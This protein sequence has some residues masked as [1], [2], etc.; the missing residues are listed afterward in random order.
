MAAL[1]V[2]ASEI[3][4]AVKLLNDTGR[5]VAFQHCKAL[6]ENV[7]YRNKE[8]KTTWTGHFRGVKTEGNIIFPEWE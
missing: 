6:A 7:A 1:T 8:N 5:W 2:T 3:M 4:E